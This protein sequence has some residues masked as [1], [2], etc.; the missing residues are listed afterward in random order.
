MRFIEYVEFLSDNH[1]V[2]P[3][4]KDWVDHIR[5]KGNEATHEIKLMGEQDAKDLLNFIEMLLRFIYDFPS[6]ISKPP[7]S[8]EK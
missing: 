3:K 7:E 4:G 1:Y 2:P 5:Q 8:K 6:R